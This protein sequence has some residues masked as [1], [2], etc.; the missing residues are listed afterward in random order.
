MARTKSSRR[1]RINAT[2]HDFFIEVEYSSTVL[3]KKMFRKSCNWS[4]A[5]HD[6]AITSEKRS[7][8]LIWMLASR[9]DLEK[10]KQELLAFIE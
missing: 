2:N 5:L 4:K 6:G 3:G 9:R 7:S 1:N 8:E 10:A